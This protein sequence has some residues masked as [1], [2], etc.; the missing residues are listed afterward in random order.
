[1]ESKHANIDLKT[2]IIIEFSDKINDDSSSTIIALL[3][4]G[5][6][7]ILF[8]RRFYFVLIDLLPF[9]TFVFFSQHFHLVGG[10]YCI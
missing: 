6:F 7:Q 8:H 2:I 3:I 9:D 5:L 1:M 4:F 10:A